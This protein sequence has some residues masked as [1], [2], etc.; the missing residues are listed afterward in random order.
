MRKVILGFL[1]CLLGMGLAP[2]G[3]AWWLEM[4]V[5]HADALLARHESG[6]PAAWKEAVA[7]LPQLIQS[8]AVK[9]VER[10]GEGGGTKFPRVNVKLSKGQEAATGSLYRAASSSE[11]CFQ[12]VGPLPAFNVLSVSTTGPLAKE[13]APVFLYRK[14]DVIRLL[15]ERD[16]AAS[17]DF[18]A[19]AGRLTF[20]VP[21]PVG[22]EMTW[23]L[24][25]EQRQWVESGQPPANRTPQ[26]QGGSP[27]LFRFSDSADS[28]DVEE[29]SLKGMGLSFGWAP[30]P[31]GGLAYDFYQK[32]LKGKSKDTYTV[33]M[34]RAKVPVGTKEGKSV[35]QR[36]EE[37]VTAFGSGSDEG[38]EV[39]EVT[40]SFSSASAP[41]KNG[42]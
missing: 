9:E 30:D 21:D 10:V 22:I 28:G 27:E 2:A 40:W 31:A 32:A 4:G 6:N 19:A 12:I 1:T 26:A 15:M 16:P 39:G 13:W 18:G 24:T 17:G 38:K 29:G 11:R 3:E 20:K 42:R 25:P 7:K 14:G 5:K 35:L 36:N 23:L 33:Y 8:G 34:A 37:K 41:A